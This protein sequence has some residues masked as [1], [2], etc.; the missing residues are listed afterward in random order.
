MPRVRRGGLNQGDAFD[1]TI[2]YE[3]WAE[4]GREANKH[5]LKQ[6]VIDKIPR[7]TFN[8]AT[9]DLPLKECCICQTEYEDNDEL[10]KLFCNHTFHA[11]CLEYW[12]KE[13]NTCPIDHLEIKAPE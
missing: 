5:P 3:Y 4:M 9:T 6:E 8:S 2:D 1:G 7:I 10:L 13:G 12:F 11:D